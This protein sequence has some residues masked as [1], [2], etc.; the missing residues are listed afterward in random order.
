VIGIGAFLLYPKE[1]RRTE[2]SLRNMKKKEE[3]PC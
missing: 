2:T 3:K 1:E